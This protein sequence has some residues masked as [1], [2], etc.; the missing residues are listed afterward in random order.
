MG[1]VTTTERQIWKITIDP[2]GDCRKANV[3]P[4]RW[5]LQ[6]NIVGI[7]WAEA[8]SH[9]RPACNT[10]E[11]AYRILCEAEWSKGK[12]PSTIRTLFEEIRAGDIICL[13]KRPRYVVAIVR[14]EQARFGPEI[15]SEFLD[16]D[17]G[18]ARN[19]DWVEIEPDLAPGFL[20]RFATIQ[21]ILARSGFRY[22]YDKATCDAI[23]AV[24]LRLHEKKR[25]DPTWRPLLDSTATAKV[26]RATPKQTIFSAMT[27]DDCED[28]ILCFLQDQGWRLLK[29]TSWRSKPDYEC[30]LLKVPSGGNDSAVVGHI[31]VKSGFNVSL[32]TEDY[33]DKIPSGEILF[34]FSS[35]ASEPYVGRCPAR[36]ECLDQD[37][38]VEW[39]RANP[40][41][42]SRPL[43]MRLHAAALD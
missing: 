31:Q 16:H 26:L 38:V 36:V 34:L 37:E 32:N 2:R 27:P 4:L 3:D 29:S 10:R 11:E 14:D 28:V 1:E 40:A 19:V 6:R 13:Y 30:D 20:Q 24:L 12:V 5:C 41:L 15:G 43:R 22:R 23:V 9:C 35:A 42:L 17:I 25:A 21:G 18:H 7:G 39:M 8:Y 33:E